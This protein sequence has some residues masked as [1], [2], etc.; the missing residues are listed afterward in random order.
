MVFACMLLG[1]V[2]IILILGII[3]IIINKKN[4]SGSKDYLSKVSEDPKA[5]G[6]TNL[7][8]FFIECVLAKCNDFS[9]Q[10]NA[11]K[12]KMFA[13]KYNLSYT[14]GIEKLYNR[15]FTAH[16]EMMSKK[17]AD[18]KARLLKQIRA[19]EEAAHRYLNRYTEYFGKN[20]KI[21]MLEARHNE[22]IVLADEQEK[23]AKTIMSLTQQREQNWAFWGGL[24][25][26]IGGFGAGVATAMDVQARNAQIRE[27]N[28]INRKAVMP[29]YMAQTDS[30]SQNRQIAE[31]ISKQIDLTK[32]K[33]VSDTTAEEIMKLLYLCNEK[34]E[35]S[36]T[37]A[38][39]VSATVKS[40]GRLFIYGDVPA[41]ADGTFLA[42]IF[43]GNREIGSVKMILPVNGLTDSAQIVGIGLGGVEVGKKY[44]A[45]IRPYKLWLMEK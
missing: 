44:T 5:V 40:K 43:D 25:D 39:K 15:A 7:D 19:E 33:M 9:Q 23:G 38:F 1:I 24:A 3:G 45:K 34:V 12:A 29:F 42:Q 6:G 30:A 41:V 18:E 35:V 32:E 14:D 27:Q 36:E 20:K 31:E 13:K 4:V 28:E 10:K 8:R 26:G 2:G 21:K 22:L 16:E 37:G 11:E 17:R